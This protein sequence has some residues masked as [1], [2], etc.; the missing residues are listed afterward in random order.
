MSSPPSTLSD[1][2][3]ARS[4]GAPAAVSFLDADGAVVQTLSYDELYRASLRDAQRL[5]AAGLSPATDIVITSF[6]DHESHIRVFWA[7][8]M[9]GIPV[10]PIPPLH[11]DPSRQTLFFAHLQSLLN[12]PTLIATKQ[13][14][15]D[16]QAVAPDIKA[17]SLADLGTQATDAATEAAV[18]PVRRIAPDDIVCLMLTSGSTGNSK[19]V[20]LRHANLLSSVRG[21]SRHHGTTPRSRFLNWIAFDHVACVS[22]IHLHA[23]ELNAHQFH[24]APSAI[25]QRPLRLLEWCSRLEIAYTF[26]PNFLMAQICRELVA[27]PQDPAA[28]L[29][30]SQMIA[31]ISGGEAVPV[32]TAVE[33]T[34]ILERCGAPRNVLRAGFGMSETGAGCIYDTRPVVRD[35]AACAEKYLSLGACCPGTAVR[36][37]SRAT[38]QPCAALE[39]GQLQLSGP[40]VFRGY[41]NNPAANAESF[42]ADGWFI[43]GDSAQLDEDGNLHLVGRD[44]DHININGVKHPSVDVEHFVE[45]AAIE[46]VARAHVFVCPMRLPDTD[47][48]TY[49]VFY[50]HAVRVEDGLTD[51]DVRRIL[52]A[53]R[54]VRNRC[55]VFCAQAPHVVLPLPRR[56]FAKTALGKVSRSALMVAYQRGD[57]AALEETLRVSAAL[58]SAPAP[59]PASAVEQAVYAVVAEVLGRDASSLRAADSLFDI[60]TSSMH[61]VRLKHGLQ[62]RLQIPDVPMIDLLRHPELGALCAFLAAAASGGGDV[63]YS[64]LICMNPHGAKPPVF[65]VHPGVGEVLVFVNLA[66]ELAADGRPVYAL[67]ARGFDAGEAPFASFAEMVA[68]YTAA[69]EAQQPAGPYHVGGYSFGGAVAFE[70]AKALEARGRAVAWVGVFNLPPHIQF[71]MRELVW[72]EVLVNLFMFLALVP[73][74]RIDAVRAQLLAA[75]PAL[76]AA[77]APPAAAHEVIDWMLTR[78]DPARR[79]QLQLSPDELARW[80]HVAYGLSSLGRSYEPAGRLRGARLSVFCAVPLPSMGTRE[81][82]KRDRLS[83][84]ADFAGAR[85]V[86][87]IDVDGEHYTMISDDHVASFAQKM[88]AAMGRA[89]AVEAPPFVDGRQDFDAIPLVD[90][91]LA[92]TDPA[93]YYAQLR[94][95][96]ED[97]GFGVFVNVPGFEDD[98]QKEFFRL[99]HE[100]FTKPQEWKDALSTD[101]SYALRGYTRADRMTGSHKVSRQPASYSAVTDRGVGPRRSLPLWS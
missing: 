39:P 61:L 23:L 92:Q 30:L 72:V 83:R 25:I 5:L 49:A 80:T 86:E 81:V 63:R 91:S 54:A 71:R 47:T 16:V 85:G 12:K 94:H 46:G 34:D 62:E 60:G 22:E 52:D 40:T 13:T 56:C 89:A 79:A 74:D 87:F 21:K 93:A 43:T 70:I 29:D 24:V 18:Y 100:L 59:E 50:Q 51:D 98:V 8:C 20:A 67:R 44:K 57:H 17:L 36:V 48:D 33:F 75:F 9:A 28:S 41:Y 77:D 88:V 64:P 101:N 32:G 11:P 19:A 73:P 3:H 55:I 97:V 35:A 58:V 1:L 38:G 37:V 69:I 15:A 2:L 53:N 27:A 99:C 65:L 14:I 82:F 68:T 45:D 78:A 10:C 95:A 26:S 4:Q 84:W 76:R 31:F 6:P 42:T 90:F 7:C 96:L 66:R